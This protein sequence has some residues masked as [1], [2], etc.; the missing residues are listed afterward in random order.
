VARRKRRRIVPAGL[1]G[2]AGVACAACCAIPLLLA[3]G[4][5][6]GAGWAAAG[7]VMPGITVGLAAVAGLAWWR[8][9][10]RRHAGGGCAGGAGCSCDDHAG[11]NGALEEPAEGISVRSSA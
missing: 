11:E 4:V 8:V 6:G 3:A 10:R 1:S 7:R 2:L 5:L 9:A